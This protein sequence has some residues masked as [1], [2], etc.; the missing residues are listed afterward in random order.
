MHRPDILWSSVSC[1]AEPVLIHRA[2]E[3]LC[4][5]SFAM[6]YNTKRKWI[7]NQRP[8][9]HST[10]YFVC[11]L[12]E[13]PQISSILLLQGDHS[14]LASKIIIIKAQCMCKDH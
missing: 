10:R 6:Y 1:E 3:R 12:F 9:V 8:Q 13:T 2:A 7:R 5:A 4:T 14:D 11:T